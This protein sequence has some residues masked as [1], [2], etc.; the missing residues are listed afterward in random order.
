[1]TLTLRLLLVAIAGILF[2]GCSSQSGEST[3]TTS[4]SADPGFPL[5]YPGPPLT[6]D[7]LTEGILHIDPASKCV[8]L[9]G[10]DSVSVA[11][12][13]EGAVIDM[14]DAANPV[15]VLEGCRPMHDGELI[16]FRGV[17]SDADEEAL[18]R[19]LDADYLQRC[20]ATD[21]QLALIGYCTSVDRR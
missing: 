19:Q 2:A 10:T 13:P 21:E 8:T 7:I 1:M 3:T 17:G 20:G 4:G 5:A 14:S 18:R 9:E 15:L 16:Q 11:A 12:V 6:I